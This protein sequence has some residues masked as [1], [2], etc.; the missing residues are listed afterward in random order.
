MNINGVG[1]PSVVVAI[2]H[3]GMV[4]NMDEHQPSGIYFCLEIIVTKPISIAFFFY[5]LI[6]NIDYR[7]TPGLKK[8]FHPVATVFIINP[9][10][11]HLCCCQWCTIFPIIKPCRAIRVESIRVGHNP[12]IGFHEIAG[13]VSMRMLNSGSSARHCPRVRAYRSK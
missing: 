8:Q 9:F 12:L 4:C 2:P 5:I 6:K 7:I 11:F 1:P 13:A 10:S 3:H